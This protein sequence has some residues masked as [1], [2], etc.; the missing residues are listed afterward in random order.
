MIICKRCGFS[1]DDTSL[2]CENCSVPLAYKKQSS[3]DNTQYS[4][5]EEHKSLSHIQIPELALTAIIACVMLFWSL[6]FTENGYQNSADIMV[7]LLPFGL[8]CGFALSHDEISPLNI[9]EWESAQKVYILIPK[10]WMVITAVI[11]AVSWAMDGAAGYNETFVTSI[12]YFGILW[13]PAY[14]F[15]FVTSKSKETVR[16]M[17]DSFAIFLGMF[18]FAWLFGFFVIA[19]LEGD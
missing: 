1:N 16:N 4:S 7:L 8:I 3:S 11:A 5:S 18:P 10:I 12:L 9:F 13:V 17:L 2:L 6:G 14:A 19:I 15:T